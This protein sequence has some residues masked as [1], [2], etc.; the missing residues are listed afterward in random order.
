MKKI[1][2]L[3]LV[4]VIVG[5]VIG[6]NIGIHTPKWVEEHPG[7]NYVICSEFLGQIYEDLSD[8]ES[9]HV[10]NAHVSSIYWR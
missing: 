9:E 8:K 5:V 2:A 1:I 6:I 4:G 3:I 7:G 10:E